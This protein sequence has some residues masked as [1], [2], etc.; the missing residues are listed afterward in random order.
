[1]RYKPRTHFSETTVSIQ[2]LQNFTVICSK[3]VEFFFVRLLGY[4]YFEFFIMKLVAPAGIFRGDPDRLLKP[5]PWRLEK[6]SK[7]FHK[8][9]EKL[10]F[11]GKCGVPFCKVLIKFC[12]FLKIY[13]NF[14][15]NLAKILKKEYVLVYRGPTRSPQSWRSYQ[16]SR[17]KS[18]GKMQL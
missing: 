11:V 7:V 8:T 13:L 16:K 18:N 1:M 10:Q 6:V 15:K 14:C 4:M 5:C 17:W 2:F 3:V 12:N 9:N